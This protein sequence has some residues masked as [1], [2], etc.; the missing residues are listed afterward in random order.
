MKE[1]IESRYPVI[2][3]L[4]IHGGLLIVIIIQV[5]TGSERKKELFESDQEINKVIK[6]SVVVLTKSIQVKEKKVDIEP[7][8]NVELTK[9]IITEPIKTNDK[10]EETQSIADNEKKVISK[11]INEP[12]KNQPPVNTQAKNTTTNK[13]TLMK[14]RQFLKQHVNIAPQY[15]P[16]NEGAGTSVMNNTL[17][18]HG[19]NVV[20]EKTLE[21]K[22]EI[23]IT[24]DSVASKTT[25]LISSFTGG[26]VKCEKG[27][28]LSNF[29]KQ[30]AKPR[31]KYKLD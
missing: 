26:R 23:N 8:I 7:E 1:K 6:T 21:Q 12:F 25:A 28:D 13:S 3:S 24:C 11:T 2:W 15:I 4:L 30:K 20:E 10:I 27:P 31:F 14:S 19:Y 29:I 22:L 9:E 5:N 18:Q 16:E 17:T